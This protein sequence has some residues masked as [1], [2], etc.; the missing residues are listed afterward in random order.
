M[1]GDWHFAHLA[2]FALGGAGLIFTEASAV[3]ANGRITYGD[4]GIWS[5]AHVA[6]LRRITEFLRAHGAVPGDAIG[7]RRA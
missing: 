3:H 5:D 2:K 4:L 7:A 1:A 6:P